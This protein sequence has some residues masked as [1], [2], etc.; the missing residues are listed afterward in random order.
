MLYVN[1]QQIEALLQFI[2]RVTELAG[3]V[4]NTWSEGDVVLQA[5]IERAVHL[6][7][8]TVTDIG[9][10]L[11]DGFILRD[12]GSYEDII[13]ILQEEGVVEQEQADYLIRLVRLRKPLVQGYLTVDHKELLDVAQG[14]RNEL[15]IFSRNVRIFIA[16]ELG[17]TP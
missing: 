15:L 1:L 14:F 16:R 11:I 13:R 17:E 3:N 9:S 12:A 8:E 7:L 6:A 5:A 4:L 2:P 10:L